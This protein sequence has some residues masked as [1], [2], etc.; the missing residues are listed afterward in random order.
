MKKGTLGL[1]QLQRMDVFVA[2]NE[3]LPIELLST[4]P[5]IDVLSFQLDF[6]VKKKRS[7]PIV[8]NVQEVI[9]ILRSRH[10]DQMFSINQV[11]P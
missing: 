11:C 10:I 8:I 4:A 3:V 1:N 9:D 7:T 6:R 5:A 2:R